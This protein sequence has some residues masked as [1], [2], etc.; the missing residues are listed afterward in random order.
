MHGA[1]TAAEKRE[2]Q[3]RL[4]EI[5]ER[6]AKGQ[7]SESETDYNFTNCMF[8]GPDEAT[9]HVVAGRPLALIPIHGIGPH[10][11]SNTSYR[12]AT[13][14]CAT[15]HVLGAF[16]EMYAHRWRPEELTV[17]ESA[18]RS[19]IVVDGKSPFWNGVVARIT[20]PPTCPGEPEF[21][22]LATE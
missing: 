14:V 5:E 10:D 8:R 18:D 20:L 9:S 6:I 16:G 11:V 17:R 22:A 1:C 13:E 3:Q 4:D 15:L 7:G 19:Q 12:I 2:E 21:E